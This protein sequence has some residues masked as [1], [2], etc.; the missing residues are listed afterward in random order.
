[1]LKL[2][3]LFQFKQVETA[4]DEVVG[5]AVGLIVVAGPEGS[6]PD[7]GTW[8]DA[9]LLPSGKGMVFR[10]LA[11]E[12]LSRKPRSIGMLVT[13]G[14]RELFSGRGILR[15][16][17]LV[18]VEKTTGYAEAIFQ[19]AGQRP[20][21][22]L[23]DRLDGFT[24]EP[25]L[26][27]A[28]RG[29]AGGLRI[30]TLFDT[31]LRSSGILRQFVDLGL[32]S[33]LLDGLGWILTVQRLAVLC[34][35]CRREHLPEAHELRQ[36]EFLLE[37]LDLSEEDLTGPRPRSPLPVASPGKFTASPGCSACRYSGRRG[38]VG[39]LEIAR[40]EGGGLVFKPPGNLEIR[41]PGNLEIRLP[42]EACLWSLV[43]RGQLALG[44]LLHYESDQLLRT[45]ACLNKLEAIQGETQ[46]ALG[47]TRSELQAAARVLEHRNQA[48]F[49]FQDIGYALIRSDDLY[50]LAVRICRHAQ[51][52]CGADRTVLYILRP[53]EVVEVAAALGWAN[54]PER[55][56]LP[57]AQVFRPGQTGGLVQFGGIPPGVPVQENLLPKVEKGAAALDKEAAGQLKDHAALADRF[58]R[59][60]LFVG[61]VAQ[62][63]RVG[64]MIV[65]SLSHK[66]FSPGETAMLQAFAN[67]AALALQRAGLVEDLRSKITELE[68]AQSELAEKE[69]MA[70]E[71]E[72][73]RQ[74]QQSVLPQRFPD[75]PGY[76]F[77]ARYEAARQVGGDFYDVIDLDGDRFGLAV[78]DVSDKGM[79]A[80]LYM[81]LTRSLLL[82]QARRERSPRQVLIEVNRLLMEVS[83]SDMFVTVF[84]GV[85]EKSSRRLVFA[86]AGHDRPFLL[87][88]G[89]CI[90]LGGS[91]AAL[92]VIESEKIEIEEHQMELRGGDRLVLFTD[93][94]TDTAAPNLEFFGRPRLNALLR[95]CAHLGSKDL[96]QVVFET[97]KSYQGSADQFDD[98]TMLVVDV[99]S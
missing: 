63:E 6:L 72:L 21:L 40:F 1:M 79:P 58:P 66:R 45:A 68:A 42:I 47:R 88:S 64:A 4:L 82:A 98:M 19:A 22:L 15:K 23:V 8:P 25:I 9:C 56:R 96:C 2:N 5:A 61:L 28:R 80:A 10:T 65:Q 90:D 81:A 77:A 71:M 30:L 84:Y 73:A 34:P 7:E 59:A 26:E 97:L 75:I 92:G 93:G 35:E 11:E 99:G 12:L 17:H 52:L 18:K 48:L 69:R 32:K 16:V 67:Q 57:A 36:L 20:D 74:V 83:S 29:K 86:R 85:I 41:S 76:G 60:G 50:E 31:P 38:D 95:A 37:Q 78:A 13:D 62:G 44:D 49:S 70:R 55:A 46:A 91:G 24:A 27:A 14:R 54:V 3:D 87:R 39:V 43:Q 33:E 89:G 94:L 51:E 53:G